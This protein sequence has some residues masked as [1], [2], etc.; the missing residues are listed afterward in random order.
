MH[1]RLMQV[2]SRCGRHWASPLMQRDA[3]WDTAAGSRSVGLETS[4]A[5]N[6]EVEEGLLADKE[7]GVRSRHDQ[8][9]AQR[10]LLLAGIEKE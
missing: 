4:S 7:R 9:H 6:R 1:A 3:E 5:G 2:P 10:P 8:D